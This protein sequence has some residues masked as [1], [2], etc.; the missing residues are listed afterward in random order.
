MEKNWA[1]KIQKVIQAHIFYVILNNSFHM[2][3]ID[4]ILHPLD[5]QKLKCSMSGVMRM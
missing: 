2:K 4:Y 1:I 3:T 5:W